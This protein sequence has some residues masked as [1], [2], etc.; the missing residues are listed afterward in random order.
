MKLLTQ[1]LPSQIAIQETPPPSTNKDPL[2]AR[3]LQ[4]EQ[5]I[6]IIGLAIALI[7]AVGFFSRRVEYAIVFAII[8]S[9]VLIAF[10]LFV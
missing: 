6:G 7:A 10:F 2:I 5:Y 8:L 4:K 3:N 1:K 9:A